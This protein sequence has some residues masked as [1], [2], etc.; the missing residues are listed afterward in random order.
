[1]SCGQYS[2]NVGSMSNL[3]KCEAPSD[4][5]SFKSLFPFDVSIC[6][7]VVDCL[8]GQ[9]EIYSEF[10]CAILLI[11][12]DG[13]DEACKLLYI[14]KDLLH[15]LNVLGLLEVELGSCVGLDSFTFTIK[16]KG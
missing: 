1:M 8:V 14:C 5:S 6:T 10:Y 7:Q 16:L 3:C 12:R 15:G 13:V 9:L 11:L 2:F 4:V